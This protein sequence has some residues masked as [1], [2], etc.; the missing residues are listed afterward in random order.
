MA[1]GSKKISVVAAALYEV[2]MTGEKLPARYNQPLS[3]SAPIDRV[4]ASVSDQSLLGRV[5][6]GFIARLNKH[7][8]ERNTEE[9]RA[10]IAYAEAAGQ[11][12]DAALERDRKIARYRDDRDSLIK[13]DRAQHDH[14]MK[15]NRLRRERELRQAQ[16]EDELAE[17]THQAAAGEAKRLAARAQWGNDAF[18]QS[19]PYRQERL[20]HLFKSGAL[21]A[22]IEMLMRD[23]QRTTLASG[24]K[25]AEP[26][27]TEALQQLL[28]A[29]KQEI[30]LS[31]ARH[32]SAD[33]MIALHGFRARLESMIE[34]EKNRPD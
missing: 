11:L 5:V 1:G 33:V 29:L 14:Q 19:L 34:E 6:S 9:I 7:T 17:Q 25:Q 4:H 26:K 3:P 24:Q 22:E 30:E 10:H 21:D 12:R 2:I 27:Q 32:A 31:Q 15:L 28:E 16:R 8:I 23:E 13:D 18:Q 20:D